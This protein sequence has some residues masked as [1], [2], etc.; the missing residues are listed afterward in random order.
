MATKPLQCCVCNTVE[1]PGEGSTAKI[2]VKR[3]GIRAIPMLSGMPTP[4]FHEER[5]MCPD[6]AAKVW[7]KV[8]AALPKKKE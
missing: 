4:E 6:C 8:E 1:R 2:T 5:D 7:V 3:Y